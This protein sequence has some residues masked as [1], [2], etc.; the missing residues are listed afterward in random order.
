MTFKPGDIVYWVFNNGDKGACTVKELNGDDS[1]WVCWH[2]DNFVNIM[3]TKGF[4]RGHDDEQ[5]RID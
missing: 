1:M 2:K 3:P 4:V 5:P